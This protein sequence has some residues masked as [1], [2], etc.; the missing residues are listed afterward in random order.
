M[1]ALND[2]SSTY[3]HQVD[4]IG[5]NKALK[6]FG[7]NPGLGTTE[8]TVWNQ[9]G[10]ETYVASGSNTIDTI[11]SSNAG[12]TQDVVIEGHTDDGTGK[13][14]VVQTATLNGQNKVVLTTPLNRSTR[15]YNNDSTDFTGDIYV[16]EDDTLTGGVPNTASKIHLKV[17]GGVDINQSLK[18]ATSMSRSDYWIVTQFY[19]SVERQQSR[20]VDFVLKV[21]RYGK[22]YRKVALVSAHS[23]GGESFLNFDPC[24]IVPANADVRVDATSS[25]TSTV[26]SATINGYLATIRNP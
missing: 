12:D 22:V 16:Y 6:K 1:A 15:L 21:R 8:E 5:K 17:S 19:C 25:G 7:E 14:F 3:G 4:I 26:C 20:S 24:L 23:N 18:C 2:I 13:D 9:G 11:S 10:K